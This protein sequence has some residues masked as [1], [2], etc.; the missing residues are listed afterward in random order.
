MATQRPTPLAAGPKQRGIYSEYLGASS[1]E[2]IKFATAGPQPRAAASTSGYQRIRI[3]ASTL[4]P[5][6]P[7]YNLNAGT[8]IA[9]LSASSKFVLKPAGSGATV[10]EVARQQSDSTYIPTSDVELLVDEERPHLH[11]KVNVPYKTQ[12]GKP[13]RRIEIERKRRLFASQNIQELLLA[14]GVDYTRFGHDKDHKTGM[15]S[16]LPLHLYDDADLYYR[17][18][19]EWIRLGSNAQGVVKIPAKALAFPHP[20]VSSA[21]AAIAANAATH[22]SASSASGDSKVGDNTTPVELANGTWLPCTVTGW[23]PSTGMYTI[24]WSEQA[25]PFVLGQSAP[26]SHHQKVTAQ[27]YPIDIVMDCEDPLLFARRVGRAHELRREHE[28]AIRYELYIN[29]MPV[30]ELEGLDTEQA[31]RILQL[32]QSTP[33]LAAS[34]IDT[35]ALLH[36]VNME[37]AR[38]MNKIIFDAALNDPSQASIRT[39]LAPGLPPPSELRTFGSGSV[40]PYGRRRR[41]A[42]QTREVVPFHH[43]AT[44]FSEFCFQSVFN[45]VEALVA[46]VKVNAECLL[47]RQCD[48]FNTRQLSKAMRPEEFEQ[49][50]RGTIQALSSHLRDRWVANLRTAITTSLR[51]VGKG[52]FNLH[53]KNVEVYQFSK[54]K[55]FMTVINFMMQDTIRFLVQDAFAKYAAFIRRMCSYQAQIQSTS[56][57][58]LTCNP[59]RFIPKKDP[60]RDLM[61]HDAEAY[62][63]ALECLNKDFALFSIELTVKDND[64]VLSTPLSAFPPL[65]LAQ[66]DQALEAMHNI[67]Q[68]ETQVMSHLFPHSNDVHLATVGREEPWVVELVSQV[69]AWIE[70]ALKPV[71]EYVQLF[72]PHKRLLMTDINSVLADWSED[73]LDLDEISALIRRHLNEADKIE[74]QIPR[75]MNLGLVVVSCED[76]RRQLAVRHR[77]IATKQLERLA[78]QINERCLDIANLFTQIDMKLSER[79]ADIRSLVEMV[80]YLQQ[81]PTQ[82][83]SHRKAIQEVIS[84]FDVLD[85]FFFHIPDAL[86]HTKWTTFHYP[87]LIMDRVQA[88]EVELANDRKSFENNLKNDRAKLAA[89]LQKL[90][91]EIN[92]FAAVSDEQRN[93]E[94]AAKAKELNMLLQELRARTTEINTQETLFGQSGITDSR[95]VNKLQAKFEPYYLLWTTYDEWITNYSAWT[96][97]PFNELDGET[98]QNCVMGYLKTLNKI[99]KSKAFMATA[100]GSNQCQI[101]AESL[102]ANVEKFKPCLPLIIA[103]R[104]PGMRDRH[105]QQL[106]ERLP[107]DARFPNFDRPETLTLNMLLNNYDLQRYMDT[108]VSTGDIATKEYQIELQ[109]QRM[110]RAWEGLQFVLRPHKS[111]TFTIAEIDPITQLL[112]E[113]TMTAQALQYS[114]YKMYFEERIASWNARLAL[115]NEVLVEWLNLQRQWMGLQAIFSSPDIMKQLTAEGRMFVQVNKMWRATMNAAHA[116]PHV[117]IHLDSTNNLNKFQ[118]ANRNLEVIQKRL[119]DYLDKKRAAFARLSFLSDDELIAIL[120]HIQDPMA[121]QPYVK[122]CFENIDKLEFLPDQ[123]IKGMISDM[124]ERID[125]LRPIDP[126]GQNV[127]TWLSQVETQMIETLRHWIDASIK[128]YTKIPRVQWVQKWPAQCVL[129]GS[130]FH[131]TYEVEQE[132]HSNGLAGIE[133]YLAFLREQLLALVNIMRGQISPLVHSTLSALIVLDVHARDVVDSLVKHRVSTLNDFQWICQMRTYSTEKQLWIQMLQSRF[134]YGYEYLG[135]TDRLVI[136][137]LTDRCFMT[138]M[139]ALSLSMGGSPAGPAGTGKTETVKCLSKF[140]AKQCVVFNCSEGLNA[141]FMSKFFRGLAT[142][143]AWSC[144]DEFNRIDITVLSVVAQQIMTLYEAVRKRVPAFVFEDVEISLNPTCAVFVTMNPDYAGRTELPDNLKALLRPVAM[145]VPDYELIARI[146]LFSFGFDHADTLSVK[147]AIT[148]KLASEQ[149]SSQAHYDFGMRTVSAV[150]VRSG[151]LKKESPKENENYLVLR[152]LRDVNVP[153]LVRQDLP[154]FEGIISDLFPDVVRP[155]IDYGSLT[156]AL[157]LACQKNQLQPTPTFIHKCIQLYETVVVRHGIM[158]VGA[159]GA[160]KSCARQALTDALDML[161]DIKPFRHADQHVINPKA[162]TNHQLYG[163]LDPNTKEWTDGLIAMIVSQCIDNPSTDIWQWVVFDGPVDADWIENLNSVLD[164]SKKLCL[165]NQ[166]I[167]RLTNNICLMF[168]VHDLTHASPATISRC[169]MVYI[170]PSVLGLAPLFRSWLNH[171][172]HPI[173][174]SARTELCLVFDKLVA[175]CVQ[176]VRRFLAEPV[177]SEDC[178]LVLSMLNLLDALMYPYLPVLEDG[179]IDW[180]TPA[181]NAKPR[182]LPGQTEEALQQIEDGRN[183]IR[184]NITSIAIM[185]LVWSIGATTDKAG[186]VRFDNYLR[187]LLQTNDIVRGPPDQ[188]LVYDY[189]FD[190]STQRWVR[191]VDS[192]PTFVPDARLAHYEIFVPTMDSI[193]STFVLDALVKRGRHVLFTGATGTGKTANINRYLSQLPDRYQPVSITFSAATTANQTEDILTKRLTKRRQRP[194]EIGAPVGKRVVVFVDDMNMPAREKYHAQP[195]IELLRQW[196]DYGGWYSHHTRQWTSVVEIGFIGAMGPPGGGRNPVT[197]RFIRHFHQVAHTDLDHD[198]LYLIFSTIVRAGL[199]RFTPDIQQ[200]A[201]GIVEASISVYQ[202]V[203]AEFLP[204]PTRSHYTFNLRDLAAVIHG[205]LGGSPKHITDVRTFLCLWVHEARRVFEDRLVSMENVQ[206][207]EQILMATMRDQFDCN[208]NEVVPEPLVFRHDR[209][210][211]HASYQQVHSLKDV[212]E[213][214]KQ[215]LD[216]MVESGQLSRLIL[217]EDAVEHVFR[218]SRILR[219]PGGHAL[220]LGVGGN[221]RQSLTKLATYMADYSLVEVEITKGYGMAEW[222]DTL[223]AMLLD[224]GLKEQPTVFLFSDTQ[225][226]HDGFLEDVNNLLNSGE[227]PNIFDDKDMDQIFA[228]CK[229]DCE[230]KKIP[231][232]RLNAYNQF[233]LR[234]KANLHVVLTM[235]PMGDNFRRRIRMFPSLINCCYIDWFYTWPEDAL[236]S[237]AHAVLT[238]PGERGEELTLEQIDAVVDVCVYMH[239]TV[240]EQAEIYRTK[241][242]R[243]TYVTPTSYLQLISLF[244]SL[245]IQRRGEVQS[246]RSKLQNG[247]DTLREAS[248]TI[249]QLEAALREKKPRLEARQR[250]VAQMTARIAQ[251]REEA[252]VQKQRVEQREAEAHQKSIECKALS[253]DAKADLEVAEAELK[254]TLKMLDTM[255]KSHIDEMR[256]YTKNPPEGVV[257]SMSAAAVLLEPYHPDK[258]PVMKR[259]EAT[260][261]RVPDYWNYAIKVTAKDSSFMSQLKNYNLAYLTPKLMKNLKPFIDHPHFTPE[262]IATHNKAGETIC[263]WVLAMKSYYET[264]LIVEPKRK[265]EADAQAELDRV[266]AMLAE[267]QAELD[268]VNQRLR[269]LEDQLSAAVEE[270]RAL[271]AE[272]TECEVKME[273]AKRLMGGL[274][275]EKERWEATI[276]RKNYESLHIVGDMLIAAGSMA[277]LGPFTQ[278]Y[279]TTLLYLWRQRLEQLRIAFTENS[280]LIRTMGDPVRMRMWNSLGLPTDAVSVENAI[281][282]NQSIDPAKALLSP[283]LDKSLRWPL[284]IDPQGQASKFARRLGRNLQ[285]VQTTD[286]KWLQILENAVRM[287]TWILIDNVGEE[288]DPTLMRLLSKNYAMD[289]GQPTMKLG[290]SSI[291]YGDTFRLMMTTKLANPHFSPEVQVKVALLNFTITRQGLEEQMLAAVVNKEAPMLEETKGRLVTRSAELKRK[292]QETEDRIL[293]LLSD[294]RGEGDILDKEELITMLTQSKITSEEVEVQLVEA[295]RNEI[296]IDEKR[297]AYTPVAVRATI[298]YFCITDLAA[299]DSMYQYSFEWFMSLFVNS[300]G[301]SALSDEIAKRLENINDHFTLS[302]FQNVCRSLFEKHKLVFSFLLAISILQGA[303]RIDPEEWRFLVTGGSVSA[304]SGSN[305]SGNAGPEAIQGRRRSPA[306]WLTDESWNV[307]QSFSESLPTFRG[308]DASVIDNLPHFKQYFENADPHLQPLPAPWEDRLDDFQKLIVL[309]AFR[310]DKISAAMHRFVITHLGPEFGEPAQFNIAT[311]YKDSH[312]SR[313]LLFILSRGADPVPA[314]HALA[315]DMNCR[316]KLY[317]VSLGPQQEKKAERYIN[318][319]LK[320]GGWVLLQ[321]CHLA[322]SWLPTVEVILSRATDVHEDFRL[323]LTSMPSPQ[324][325]VSVLQMSIK[326]TNEPPKGLK[327]SLR[328][329]YE[330]FSDQFLS[331]SKKPRDFKKLLYSLC[332]FHAVIL[333]RRKFGALGWNIQYDFTETDLMVCYKQLQEFIDMYDQVPYQVIHFLVYNINYGGRVTDDVDRTLI[334]TIL[335]DFI[336]PDVL[337]D[338]YAFSPSGKYVSLPA[339]NRSQYLDQIATLETYPAPEVFGMHD[340]AEITSAQ[341]ETVAMFET[342]L[343][344]LPRDIQGASRPR[345]SIILD[346]ANSILARIPIPWEIESIMKQYPSMYAESM[347]TVLTQ[348]CTL[349]NRLI[350]RIRS[351]LEDLGRAL[352]GQMVMTIDLERMADSIYNNVVP[353]A[354][355]EVAY[356]SLMPLGAWV[357]DLLARLQFINSWIQNGIPKVFWMGGF[358]LPQA[359]LTG[360]LQN[361]AR[362]RRHPIDSVKFTFHII[363]RP[364]N[365]L[366]ERPQDG[367]YVQGIFLEGARWDPVRKTITDPRPRELVSPMP[368]IWLLPEVDIRTGV[369]HDVV[370]ANVYRC[371]LYRT[372]ARKGSLSTTGHSTNFVLYVDLPTIDAAARKWIKAGVALFCA[373]RYFSAPALL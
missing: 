247:L 100:G 112:D 233:L 338:G 345:E 148:S 341:A 308:F 69:A 47:V 244:R 26:V 230:Q 299:F 279:R 189:L 110:E 229:S 64:I 330:G 318:L 167:L 46:L 22:A 302:L 136:T 295:D 62:M 248:R 242:R 271:Q 283:A 74:A 306:A 123:T 371:P 35:S 211:E 147:I 359:F 150:I 206:E 3:P 97:N 277:Y 316:D 41:A 351:T 223:R 56:A 202:R 203:C 14:Q 315:N 92:Q 245:L 116:N 58:S 261:Q 372:L 165:A 298:L 209:D 303:D 217:F 143:G 130:Q 292:L 27:V 348:E 66:F 72:E 288:L 24:I 137:P 240:Q 213:S 133:K 25:L 272:V 39:L 269:Q 94:Y 304:S 107:A 126:K 301:E 132:L 266:L 263:R 329:I 80:E 90:E 358:F 163:L 71:R 243:H 360:T 326:M 225:I 157:S 135:N 335:D 19:E 54:L 185:C 108:I 184:Q 268:A 369:A 96:E 170:E 212:V 368:V 18:P 31:N 250:E 320:N 194:L 366:L 122:K 356:P 256:S 216:N 61:H 221:G 296:E 235:S 204:T 310:P 305:S 119:S 361:F 346:L 179:K 319:A 353:S 17:D 88:K 103:L 282:M 284:M 215:N 175:P 325:P 246:T 30:D 350:T 262:F 1:E 281:I 121:V 265:R 117:Q 55:K 86:F 274:G 255:D 49:L 159:A 52:W 127:E 236:Q 50:Q 139:T 253:D 125:F 207:L 352:Q 151:R 20:S 9:A 354:W 11:P 8:S 337:Q 222:R 23:N 91:K 186:R 73:D 84:A 323:W 349:Y 355:A 362:R 106:R 195:P 4:E 264:S 275:G 13:P 234:T 15:P 115:M 93:Q 169:G 258:K 183:A 251:E 105:W 156:N 145:M 180:S 166:S 155:E 51:E 70:E 331:S 226:I 200:F 314:L 87:K 201:H 129:T 342:I 152:A 363:D 357:D 187:L 336:N 231:H 85:Q 177:P 29:S 214:M 249:M 38:T 317:S 44:H 237:V 220:L 102:K 196:M 60:L 178:N 232:T 78:Q 134:P 43:F 239:E 83:A 154:L 45:K 219:Q 367:V 32:A 79:P 75:S 140:V 53:E 168:E 120:S 285:V 114:P 260:G 276:E 333:E 294:S 153:K 81:V 82:V 280:S 161:R 57:V 334:G 5:Q 309:R 173:F 98:I 228:A 321:N 307:I 365:E 257:L 289:Q 227:V 146:K 324:F 311:S 172:L 291:P 176:F 344:I 111:G 181:P 322:L 370:P 332:F 208:W 340:N 364:A 76:V 33:Q 162:L 10:V 297:R 273:R 197:P 192:Q 131:W 278:E 300:V 59:D 40:Q 160:G 68:L 293:F 339:G 164:D 138:L 77:T 270:S 144:F 118:E 36:E 182:P 191:W 218:I 327:A 312:W 142:S 267:A 193:R 343:S 48:V 190:L 7:R 198:A 12:P 224:A 124:G 2:A 99:T 63:T 37:Y 67:P 16:Y 171:K 199:Q 6:A 259:D 205:V 104:N 128:D 101:I 158:V 89:D 95:H 34:K 174:Q 286:P 109:L 238:S 65:I 313:P 188:D 254:E 210:D 290:S 42:E 373:L 241:N 347:N 141:V 21:A 113:Q 252:A 28:A 149:L 328:R 287:G